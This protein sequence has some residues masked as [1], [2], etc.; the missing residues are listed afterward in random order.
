ME[1]LK[2]LARGKRVEVSNDK[3]LER[4]ERKEIS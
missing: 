2:I 3:M 1:L 4:D